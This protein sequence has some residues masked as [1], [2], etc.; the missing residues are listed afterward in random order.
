AF[1]TLTRADGAYRLTV[2]RASLPGDAGRLVAWRS[3]YRETTAPVRFSTSTVRTDLHLTPSSLLSQEEIDAGTVDP[4]DRG[5]WPFITGVRARL[6]SAPGG[7][8]VK[9]LQAVAGVPP[10]STADAS[11]E[12]QSIGL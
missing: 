10:Y 5:F 4:P 11:Y 6:E 12:Y 2:P 9:A 3:G 7:A 8:S 1:R